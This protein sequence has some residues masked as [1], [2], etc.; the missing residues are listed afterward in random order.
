MSVA[1]RYDTTH[2]WQDIL[3]SAFLQVFIPF[4]LSLYDS[5]RSQRPR[6]QRHGKILDA[7][8]PRLGHHSIRRRYLDSSFKY[9][10][11]AFLVSYGCHL[12]SGIWSGV[13]SSYICPLVVGQTRTV[14]AM[15]F[16]GAVL[17]CCLAIIAF[18]LCLQTHING[19]KGATSAPLVWGSILL[20][21]IPY[22]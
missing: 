21:C 7:T 10:L 9:V 11:P 14:P 12:A 5:F 13:S 8:A 6:P 3:D 18:E 1:L 19:E 17:D 22:L 20:V 16:L 4:V 15:Q 2:G